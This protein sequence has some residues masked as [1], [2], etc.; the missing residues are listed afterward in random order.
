[1]VNFNDNLKIKLGIVGCGKMATAIIKG[2]C[3][4]NFINKDNVF[5]YDKTD[6]ASKKMSEDFGFNKLNSIEEIMKKT[7]AVLIATKPFV[8][9]EVITEIKKNYDNQ[10]IMSILAGVKTE[11]FIKNIKDIKI[12]RI[13]PNTPAFV[14]EAMSA[15]CSSTNVSEDEFN[16]VYNFISNCGKTI[17][18]NED[19]I[20]II[21]ALSGSGP[22]FYF[23]II[24][25]MAKSAQKLGLDYDK[26]LL[27]S[28]Q[29]AFGS[30][31]MVMENNFDIETLIKNV[32][33]PGGCTA[34]GNDVINNS[35]MDEILDKTIKDTMQKAIELG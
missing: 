1:M 15:V 5:V 12:V 33:T 25:L 32:T 34:V 9:D 18:T 31:K 8:F 3:N 13:M 23:K 28:A 10:L 35:D 6:A 22:A 16:F 19:K 2:V 11:K 7:D 20:D 24:E 30:A 17:K 26:A 29:T 27:L 14:N 4:N 21:T